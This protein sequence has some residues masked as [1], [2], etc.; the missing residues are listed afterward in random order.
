VRAL[1]GELADQLE[2]E[3]WVIVGGGNR[4]PEEYV[5]GAGPGTKGSTFVDI[6]ARNPETGVI[7]RIQTID[8]FADGVTPTPRELINADRIRNAFPNDPLDLVPKRR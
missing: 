6:T 4:L 2:A 8:T 5:P 1:N 7:R 3:G